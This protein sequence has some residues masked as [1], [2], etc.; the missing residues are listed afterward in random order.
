MLVKIKTWLKIEKLKLNIYDISLLLLPISVWFSYQP[1]IYLGDY[2]GMHLE[3]SAT[4]IFLA[5]F[6]LINLPLIFKNLQYLMKQPAT[7]ITAVF[8]LFCAISLIWTLNLPRGILTLGIIGL[9]FLSFLAILANPKTKKLLPAIARIFIVSAVV[10]SI[11]SWL[12]MLGDV[13]GLSSELTLLCRGC[14]SGMFGFPRLTAFAIEPQ[15]FGSLLIAPILILAWQLLIKQTSRA[16]KISLIFLVATMILTLS[17]GAI[18]ALFIGI[19]LLIILV[20]AKRIPQRKSNI[21]WLAGLVLV[22]TLLALFIQGSAA[23]LNPSFSETFS[24][25]IAK[26]VHQL[27]LGIIDFR[28]KEEPKN[29]PDQQTNPEEQSTEPIFDGYVE[30][31]TDER[32]TLSEMALGA[33]STSPTSIVFG[34][35]LGSSGYAMNRSYL[36]SVGTDE[37]TQNEYTEILLELGVVGLIL[38]AAII[39]SLIISLRKDSLSLTIIAAFLIQWFFFSGYPNALHIYLILALLYVCRSRVKFSTK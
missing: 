38:F 6:A 11:V 25:S 21:G 3:L 20:I 19:F 32:L 12:Q 26:S 13:I 8:V 33:W 10:V 16:G 18:Y 4:L 7:I 1:L 36:L 24:S 2:S 34:A 22:G 39:I 29:E 23:A 30:N 9:L 28:P 15:F 14:V 27:S 5:I 35:G 37:I 31:S 17:R